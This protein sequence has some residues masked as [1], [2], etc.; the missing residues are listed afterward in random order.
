M[1]GYLTN[2]LGMVK[3]VFFLENY[4]KILNTSVQDMKI[5]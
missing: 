1:H 5:S 2:Q 3:R 4:V